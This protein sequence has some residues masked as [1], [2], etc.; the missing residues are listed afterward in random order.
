MLSSFS[1]G[2]GLTNI[3]FSNFPGRRR[4]KWLSF[5]T[6]GCQND[7][8]V[9]VIHHCLVVGSIAQVHLAWQHHIVPA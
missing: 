1:F 2:I 6:I 8:F 7:Q 3:P 5:I 4:R 9:Y